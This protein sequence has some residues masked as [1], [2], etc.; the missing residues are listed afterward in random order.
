[1]QMAFDYHRMRTD[2]QGRLR[3][4]PDSP[5]HVLAEEITSIFGSPGYEIIVPEDNNYGLI[6]NGP[7]NYSTPGIPEILSCQYV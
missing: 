4:V 1:M 6:S 2:E 7:F 3:F 5:L